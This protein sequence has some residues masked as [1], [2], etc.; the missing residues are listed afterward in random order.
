[1]KIVVRLCLVLL[2]L[3]TATADDSSS[4]DVDSR[5]KELERAVKVLTELHQQDMSVMGYLQEEVFA[6]R[7]RMESA[8]RI[9][10]PH[11]E[12]ATPSE[13]QRGSLRKVAAVLRRTLEGSE[14]ILPLNESL[15]PG[16]LDDLYD[17]DTVVRGMPPRTLSR[18]AA[19][20]NML[21]RVIHCSDNLER[22][23]DSKTAVEVLI[24]AFENADVAAIASALQYLEVQ[25]KVR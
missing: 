15:P 18:A 21:A 6:L 17:L 10:S 11:P 8:Q 24:A 22:L 14:F 2:L 20:G 13:K 3:G 12:R 1:M 19:L 23:A 4:A 7:D 5:L 25:L 16:V 9:A